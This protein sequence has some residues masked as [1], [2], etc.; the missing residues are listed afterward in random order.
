MAERYS[1]RARNQCQEV[2]CFSKTTEES[3]GG[4]RKSHHSG[5]G[6]S[7]TGVP[8]QRSPNRV[9]RMTHEGVRRKD[10]YFCGLLNIIP[11]T[12]QCVCV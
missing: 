12:F 11:L 9:D 1:V 3:E 4:R 2:S 5:P 10:E 6:Q 7:H 8:E